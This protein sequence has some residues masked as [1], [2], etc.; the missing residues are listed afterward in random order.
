M[1]S[2]YAPQNILWLTGDTTSY[3]DSLTS[4]NY[5]VTA[6][7]TRGCA[8]TMSIDVSSPP[9][10]VLSTNYNPLLCYG[11]SNGEVVVQVSGGTP[12]YSYFLNNV[13]YQDSIISNL[14]EGSHLVLVSDS[15]NCSQEVEILFEPLESIEISFDIIPASDSSSDDGVA[16]AT[17]IG[18]LA[19]YSFYWLGSDSQES[20]A[21]YLSSGW[22]GLEVTDANG[23]V[24]ADSVFVGAVSS[25]VSL[26]Q[27]VVAFPN[28]TSGKV[29]FGEGVDD[30]CVFSHKGE[31][32]IEKIKSDF[33][34]LSLLSSGIYYISLKVGGDI[35]MFSISRTLD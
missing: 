6:T 34:D 32:V 23:C 10:L 24:S 5:F 35:Q 2:I 19:P 11:A 7:D 28:P 15:N 33:I 14:G 30:I 8:D 21:V 13:E 12:G 20:V 1:D 22:Y 25:L 16:I 3:I 18:G 31:L 17:V 26:E 27:K 4:G 29:Y 9:P